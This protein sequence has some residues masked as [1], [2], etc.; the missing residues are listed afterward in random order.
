MK[1]KTKELI[2]ISLFTSLVVVF[3]Y[4]KIPLPFSPV[5]ITLQTFAVMLAGLLLPPYSAFLSMVIYLLLGAAGIPVFAGGK[6]GIGVIFGPSGG[7][8]LSWPFAALLIS[9]FI[10]NIRN[11]ISV[12]IL[13]LI[14]GVFFI[15]L[16]GVPYLSF[17]TKMTIDKAIAVGLIPFIP[18]DIFKALFA[19]YLYFQLKK[20]LEKIM[21]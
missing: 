17:V 2:F 14:F 15:Y 11:P 9:H 5:P 20:P 7:Y 8:L 4:I 19:T 10:K 6:A 1:I 12:F 13:N 18:G 21:L 16:I 3:S